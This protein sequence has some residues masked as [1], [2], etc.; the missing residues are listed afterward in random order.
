MNTARVNMLIVGSVV[1]AFVVMPQ[2][3]AAHCDTL[4]GPVVK[5]AKIAIEKADITPVL[6]WVKKDNEQEIKNAFKKTLAVRT[7][8]AE[9]KE[10]AD[11]YFFETLVRIHRAGEGAPYTGLKPAGSDLNPAVAEADKAIEKG[12]V[13]GLVK[14]VNNAAETG[15]KQRFNKV[16]EAKKDVDKTP[17]AGRKYVAAYVEF[18][19]YG[20]RLYDDAAVKAAHAHHSDETSEPEKAASE[21]EQ[22]N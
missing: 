16:M 22:H 3:A 12:N 8:S 17:E 10:L 21:H 11:M 13:E 5:D 6:K 20:E 19:H 9:A 4:D 14:L 18:V 2:I 7:K 1:F 15:L